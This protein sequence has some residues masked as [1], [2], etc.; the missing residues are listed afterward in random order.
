MAALP[1]GLGAEGAATLP[2]AFVTA[3]YALRELARLVRG[4]RVL[5][6]AATGGVGLAA[7]QV[8][9]R[10]GAEVFATA[11]PA[12]QPLVAGLGVAADRIASSR[13]LDFAGRVGD[14]DPAI[15][16]VQDGDEP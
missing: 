3:A 1:P 12:K 13:T 6:H 5:I 7:L 16:R 9:R 10:A 4:E 11:S 14:V 15:V 2:V 8:A